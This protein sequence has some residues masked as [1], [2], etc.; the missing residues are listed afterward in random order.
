MTVSEE[1]LK[2]IKG[3]LTLEWQP[4]LDIAH[5]AEVSNRHTLYALQELRKREEAEYM[6]DG[7]LGKAY[8]RLPQKGFVRASELKE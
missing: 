3:V 6:W 4:T 7:L 2:K 1:C 5:W 8:W